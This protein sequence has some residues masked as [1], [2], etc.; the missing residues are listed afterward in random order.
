MSKRADVIEAL[1]DRCET[2][3]AESAL[4]QWS[5]VPK[6]EVKP[7]AAAIEIPREGLIVLRIV[8]FNVEVQEFGLGAAR[9]NKLCT[10][11]LGVEA[12]LTDQAEALKDEALDALTVELGALIEDDP[13]LEGL[14]DET[15]INEGDDEAF[16]ELGADEIGGMLLIIQSSW[17]SERSL[18]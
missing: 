17:N 12:Y 8:G 18:A 3:I 6:V 7:A 2:A 14:V 16:G 11:T 5:L 4:G 15:L 1:K 10:L 9:I 13:T